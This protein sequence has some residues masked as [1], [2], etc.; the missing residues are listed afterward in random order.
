MTRFIYNTILYS[1]QEFLKVFSKIL[2]NVSIIP[3]CEIQQ[4]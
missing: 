2:E 1:C 3:Q 4:P